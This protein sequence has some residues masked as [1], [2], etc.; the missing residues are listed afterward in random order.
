MSR[1]ERAMRWSFPLINTSENKR[2]HKVYTPPEFSYEMVGADASIRGGIRPFPGFTKVHELMSG[3]YEAIDL[4]P[5]S[6]RVG[7]TGYAY[8]FVYRRRTGVASATGHVYLDYRKVDRGV[9][10]GWATES[11]Q[12]PTNLDDPLDVAVFGKY[13][14]VFV[15]E[16]APYLCY[17][18]EDVA[19]QATQD[20][21]PG[22]QPLLFMP[23]DSDAT[24]AIGD[25]GSG[26]AGDLIDFDAFSNVAG[27]AQVWPEDPIPGPDHN[28]VLSGETEEWHRLDQ[29]N[30][31]FAYLL[32]DSETGR[33]SSLSQ[34]GQLRE[35]HFDE[36]TIA[37][38][39]LVVAVAGAW[40]EKTLT[41]ND[42]SHDDAST[43]VF[44]FDTGVAT[45]SYSDSTTYTIGVSGAV[46]KTAIATA[47]GEGINLANTNGHLTISATSH[48]YVVTLTN[49]VVGSE[50]NGDVTTT[51]AAGFDT[52]NGGISVVGGLDQVNDPAYVSIEISW[53]DEKFDK[54]WIFRSV[55]S[56]DAGG[57]FSASVLQLDK[58]ITLEDWQGGDDNATFRYRLADLV[59]IYQEAYTDRSV[60]DEFV[61][62]AGAAIEYDG[63]L[64]LSNIRG[65]VAQSMS[66]EDRP[67]DR[68]RGLGEFRWSSMAETNPELFPP[69]NFFVPTSLANEVITF[70]EV[71]GVILGLSKSNVMH[72]TREV[73][74]F[75]SFFKIMP[76]HTGYGVVG[77]YASEVVG[78]AVFYLTSKGLKSCDAQGRLDAIHALDWLFES[79]GLDNLSDVSIAL[80]S[81]MST[82]FVMNPNNGEAGIMWFAS[83]SITELHDLPFNKVV[84][85]A[86]PSDNNDATS[87][88]TER[89]F[90]LQN[91]VIDGFQD[92]AFESCVW[93]VDSKRERTISG[94]ATAAFNGDPRIT[95][96]DGAGD[97]RFVVET[98]TLNDPENGDRKVG[99]VTDDDN[100]NFST[101][102]ED[103]VGAWVYIIASDDKTKIGEK[104]QI[105]A[106]TGSDLIC[107]N[108]T[109]GF[110]PD[111]DDNDHIGISPVYT[112]WVGATLGGNDMDEPT[113][114]GPNVHSLRLVDSLSAYFSDVSGPPSDDTVDTKDA[115]FRGLVYEGNSDTPTGKG[116]PEDLSGS[117]IR[118]VVDGESTYWAGFG[119]DAAFE[120][121]HSIKG[122]ALSP[123]LEIFCP[124]LDFRLLGTI[125]E[126]KILPSLRTERPS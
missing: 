22:R 3:T 110:S 2:G 52:T 44:T 121:K 58:I 101:N 14:Y 75:A 122:T 11:L 79:W 107:V 96:L 95:L 35:S 65:D 17:F 73:S 6:F 115:I 77:N 9:A 111:P 102:A 61:P 109:S 99:L 71:G 125:I 97:T 57:T 118:S 112:R 86:W 76:I 46:T 120:G 34:I 25:G 28:T 70:N 21:G 123:G 83:S 51:Y 105:R 85:G 42:G 27:V 37:T 60:F 117:I 8:G 126:G 32:Y 78:P 18:D 23:E 93:V 45:H 64:L 7:T 72:I 49:S 63:T 104:A 84:S 48:S 119:G 15:R 108:A 36:S 16:H 82:L 41:I 47:I 62:R 19:F 91:D 81:E 1:S 26:L 43:I 53:D 30:Y 100:H 55:K 103:W 31:A 20:T 113:Q 89:A 66:G 106:T 50:G 54:A 114:Q 98:Y 88:L 39:T 56:E 29:G 12:T 80:D 74:G 87:A 124:D 13:L 59:H 92:V 33:K 24:G 10:A 38:G 94:S 67:Y 68:Y 5:V 40:D 69:E 4:K 90:F 116:I